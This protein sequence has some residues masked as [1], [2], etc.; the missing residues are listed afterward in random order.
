MKFSEWTAVPAANVMQKVVGRAS[1]RIF[2]GLP[3]CRDPD[4]IDL[5]VDHAVNSIKS[6]LLVQLFPSF[7]K[8]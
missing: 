5:N 8:P 1:N 3:K 4:W 6:I 2:V 7:L